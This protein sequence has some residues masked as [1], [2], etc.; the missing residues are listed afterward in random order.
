MR[1]QI[2]I[3]PIKFQAIIFLALIITSITSISF[4]ANEYPKSAPITGENL[5][6]MFDDGAE[7]L[8]IDARREKDYDK[9]H[10]PGA[11]NL[12]AIDTNA[13]TLAKIAPDINTKLVFYCQNVKCQASPIAA[14]KAIGAGYRYVYE[15]SKGIEGWK[16]LGFET[17]VTEE[18]RKF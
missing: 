5:K 8:L 9:E 15:Y 18:V 13:M 17:K 3:K 10:I 7:F 11:I 14:S 6:K 12:S 2:N 4:A 1:K 16:K